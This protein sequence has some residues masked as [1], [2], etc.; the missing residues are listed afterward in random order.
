M[1]TDMV[2]EKNHQLITPD[3]SGFVYS[4]RIDFSD[5][6]A[7][8]F[9]YA[10]SQAHFRFRGTGIK[11]IIRNYHLCYENYIGYVIDQNIQGKLRLEDSDAVSVLIIPENLDDREHDIILFKRQD[12]AHYYDFLGILLNKFSIMLPAPDKPIRRMECYGDSVSAG[13]VSEAVEYTAMSD[14]V[15]NGEYS[16]SWYS[17]TSITARMLGAELHC[18]AQGGLA[19]LDHTGY[20]HGPDYVGL[21][22]TYNK[23]RYNSQLGPYSLWDFSL[24]TPHVVIVAI[25]QNDA[26]PDNY[27]NKDIQKSEYWMQHYQSLI[28]NFRGLYPST[29]IILTTTILNHSRE[30]DDAIDDV[31]NRLNDPKIV[32]FLYSN[33]GCGT[34]GHIRISEAGQMA[35]ELANFIES[36]GTDIWK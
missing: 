8:C 29:L 25:G 36:F 19:L 31:T 34:P 23:L 7:P 13:E 9:I 17:Y 3:H 28:L 32:H 26:H 14:P 2:H 20:F 33:N 6:C 1:M 21:E 16:N 27:M 22:T 24:Y 12:S 18:N 15:H 30:W 11:L 5:S 10:G 35:V 4:G